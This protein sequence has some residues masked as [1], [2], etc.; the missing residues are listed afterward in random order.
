MKSA[1]NMKQKPQNYAAVVF[2]PA[3]IRWTYSA[4]TIRPTDFVKLISTQRMK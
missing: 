3:K 2:M 1:K 4:I